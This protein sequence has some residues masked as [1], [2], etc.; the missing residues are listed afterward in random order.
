MSLREFCD[1]CGAEI[2]QGQSNH[3]AIV[4]RWYHGREGLD[5]PHEMKFCEDCIPAGLGRRNIVTYLFGAFKQ[6]VARVRGGKQ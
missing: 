5:L 3:V 6:A 4:V 2:P 1:S